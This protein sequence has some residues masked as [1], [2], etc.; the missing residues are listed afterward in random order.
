MISVVINILLNM[1]YY[2]NIINNLI[3]LNVCDNYTWITTSAV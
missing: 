3:N 2:I 1:I